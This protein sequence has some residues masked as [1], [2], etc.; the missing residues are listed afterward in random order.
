MMSSIFSI[1]APVAEKLD[2]V[3]SLI[4]ENPVY[5]PIPVLAKF[6]EVGPDGLWASIE[7]GQCPFGIPWQKSGRG[8]RA[9]KVPTVPFYLW[10]TQGTSFRWQIQKESEARNS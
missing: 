7:H 2:E 5:I 3:N 4:E 6:L 8:N 10:Y 1:P 9:F